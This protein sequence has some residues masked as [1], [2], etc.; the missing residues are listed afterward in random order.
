MTSMLLETDVQRV[1]TGYGQPSST[2][3]DWTL[4]IS[5]LS[6]STFKLPPEIK[7]RLKIEQFSD[8]VSKMLY[9]NRRDPV[10]LIGDD[11]RP[12]MTSFLSKDYDELESLVKL[13]SSRTWSCLCQFR[14]LMS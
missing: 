3:F 8:K 7:N 4:V 2:L 11:E 14:M 9:S 1:A 5:D 6:D 13:D 12:T 10:G